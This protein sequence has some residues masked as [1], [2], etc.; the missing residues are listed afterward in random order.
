MAH[1]SSIGLRSGEYGGWYS[2]LILFFS[3]NSI[4]FLA[5]WGLA[6]SCWKIKFFDYLLK[7]FFIFGKKMFSKQLQYSSELTVFLNEYK[8]KVPFLDIA[9]QKWIFFLL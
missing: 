2:N 9:P 4:V 3:R 1:I 6:L 5:T 8:G 7:R